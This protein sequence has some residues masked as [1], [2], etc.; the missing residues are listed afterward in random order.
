MHLHDAHLV[1][2]VPNGPFWARIVVGSKMPAHGVQVERVLKR[3]CTV[4]AAVESKSIVG[5]DRMGR[6]AAAARLLK[7]TIQ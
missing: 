5:V 1:A 4:P 7:W 6:K 2:L 3:A